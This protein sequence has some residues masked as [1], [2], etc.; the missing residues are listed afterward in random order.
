MKNVTF[1]LKTNVDFICVIVL[2][3]RLWRNDRR[4]REPSEALDGHPAY[5]PFIVF[6]TV[7]FD[8]GGHNCGAWSKARA[9]GEGHTEHGL[10]PKLAEGRPTLRNMQAV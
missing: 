4:E 7:P 10:L 9:S 5:F 1:K 2:R 8:R 6:Q 3:I